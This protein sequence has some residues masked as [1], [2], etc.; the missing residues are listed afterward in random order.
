MALKLLDH[1]QNQDARARV[2]ENLEHGADV[3]VAQIAMK[4][5]EAVLYLPGL[6]GAQRAAVLGEL[7]EVVLVELLV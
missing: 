2:L 1:L 6:L 5:A 7:P 3:G 4:S